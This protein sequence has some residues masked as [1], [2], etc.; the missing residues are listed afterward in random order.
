MTRRAKRSPGLF[1]IDSAAIAD[2][3]ALPPA[4]GGPAVLR[5]VGGSAVVPAG[6]P[7]RE[8]RVKALATT[9]PI[10]DMQ[11]NKSL[12]PGWDVYDLYD[13]ALATIDL[14][15]DR[16]SFDSGILRAEL[17]ELVALDAARFAPDVKRTQHRDVAL[18]VISALID[19]QVSGYHDATDGR[20]RRFDFRLLDEVEGGAGIYLRATKEAINVLVGA[21]DTDLE[22][23]HAAAEARL[24]NLIRRKKLPD[25]A[26]AARDARYR[27]VQFM[28]EVQRLIA[29]TR[30]DIRQ[31]DWAEAIPRRLREMLEHLDERTS[32][33]QKMLAAMREARDE[34]EDER[35]ERQAAELV[36]TVEE[37]YTRHTEL[38][39]RI[40]E[41]EAAFFEEQDRQS[42][43]PPPS[44]RTVDLTDELLTPLLLL[45]I[46][47]AESIAMRFAMRVW[48]PQP[49]ITA[50]WGSAVAT[51][52]SHLRR[53]SFWASRLTSLSG[54]IPSRT[55]VA[56]TTRPGS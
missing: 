17:D 10:H 56:S 15:V 40:M 37:C 6:D 51:C 23:A 28:L 29:E 14:V 34:A 47:L 18:Y 52:S 35:L 3:E 45:P 36:A 54:T 48:G 43:A 8:R 20:R 12:R 24:A 39:V 42:F 16:M 9:A 5:V 46:N 4:A 27:S 33:E 30:R 2:A 13:L 7:A 53:V 25:A 38:H 49:P 32:E 41:A 11:A 1:S 21:L 55:L 50:R 19:P 31:A 44:L 22:S 26:Q